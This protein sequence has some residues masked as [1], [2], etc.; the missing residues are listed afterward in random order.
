MFCLPLGVYGI[1]Q[2]VQLVG[3]PVTIMILFLSWLY[4]MNLTEVQPKIQSVPVTIVPL[5]AAKPTVS[6]TND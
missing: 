5:D 4:A 6:M 1:T 2:L 3:Y